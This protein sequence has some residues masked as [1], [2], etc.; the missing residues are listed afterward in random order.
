[1]LP[2]QPKLRRYTGAG[3]EA[4]RKVDRHNDIAMRAIEWI[5]DHVYRSGPQQFNFRDIAGGIDAPIE[6]VRAALPQG[7]ANG[8]TFWLT[9]DALAKIQAI[10]RSRTSLRASTARH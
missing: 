7:N 5:E 2:F 6:V 9:E 8:V 3:P 10:V 4:R 1:M